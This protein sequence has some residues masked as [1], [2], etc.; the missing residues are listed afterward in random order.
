[1]RDARVDDPAPAPKAPGPL[2]PVR[3]RPSRGGLAAILAAGSIAVLVL[4]A[5]GTWQLYRLRWKLDLIATVDARV[6]AAPIAP[7][8]PSVWPAVTADADQYLH[9]TARGTYDNA[10][11]TFVQAV[12]EDG[13]G[14]WLLTPFRTDAGFTVLVNRGFVP[15]DL[16]DPATRAAGEIEGSTQV[17][18]LLRVTEPGG[19]FLRHNDP[20]ADRWF[21][22]DVGA[23]AAKR[24]LDGL[25]APYFIDADKSPVPGGFPVGGLTVV[26]FPNSHL[27]YA[28][29]WYA[30][31][32]G[33]AGGLV[34]VLREERRPRA[35]R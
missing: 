17:T 33:L 2:E 5:L 30:M 21:S 23:I 22:R 11:E 4:M 27:V 25:V 13:A 6:H 1:M 3:R 15:S 24:G 26:A 20:A 7:P 18:G 12:T 16:R 31:G 9:V 29:T 28:L 32:L 14:Y 34:W 19:A 10:R 35:P 8:A